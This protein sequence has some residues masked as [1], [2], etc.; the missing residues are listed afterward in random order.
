MEK[1]NS[2]NMMIYSSSLEIKNPVIPVEMNPAAQNKCR[3]S[4]PIFSLFVTK[5]YIKF[6]IIIAPIKIPTIL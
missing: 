6:K 3:I 1:N 2:N 4:N 5:L